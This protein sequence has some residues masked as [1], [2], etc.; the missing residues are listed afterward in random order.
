MHMLKVC[1][2]TVHGHGTNA[3]K[4]YMKDSLRVTARSPYRASHHALTVPEYRTEYGP[5]CVPR[6]CLHYSQQNRP[7]YHQNHIPL[8]A[9][10]FHLPLI[11]VAKTFVKS[12]IYSTNTAPIGMS[13]DK[14]K[15]A[16]L[17]TFEY[18]LQILT[19]VYSWV[20][21]SSKHFLSKVCC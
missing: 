15:V 10:T 1:V 11:N 20:A 5:E 14:L 6:A 2:F 3:E 8:F 18:M 7:D 13:K 19:A 4:I 9:F 16:Y 12:C 17:P 21:V